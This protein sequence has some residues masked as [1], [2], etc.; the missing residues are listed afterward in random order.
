MQVNKEIVDWVMLESKSPGGWGA[1]SY[2]TPVQEVWRECDAQHKT[3][4]P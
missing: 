3:P 4:E 1:P 2:E